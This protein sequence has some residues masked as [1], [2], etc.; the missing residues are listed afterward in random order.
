MKW[1]KKYYLNNIYKK[2][3]SFDQNE[4][5]EILNK[6]YKTNKKKHFLHIYQNKFIILRKKQ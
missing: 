2:L 5:E 3:M 4:L 1:K 6:R